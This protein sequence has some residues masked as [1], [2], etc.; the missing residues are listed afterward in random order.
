M[1]T[2]ISLVV[3]NVVVVLLVKEKWKIKLEELYRKF[4][5]ANHL[6]IQLFCLLLKI[7]SFV[8]IS[9][10]FD[11][12]DALSSFWLWHQNLTLNRLVYF[13]TPAPKSL[14]C[15]LTLSP[16]AICSVL[17][18]AIWSDAQ[19]QVAT[20]PWGSCREGLVWCKL[21]LFFV[22]FPQLSVLLS[23]RL[24][25]LAQ[26]YDGADQTPAIALNKLQAHS[27]KQTGAGT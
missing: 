5:D 4:A 7:H 21:N 20:T 3:W 9:S 16:I 8:S 2:T 22:C 10:G 14:S 27:D 13:L 11:I 23:A 17:S 15:V 26:Q 25:N 18:F 6:S 1:G 19:S 24:T 12:G